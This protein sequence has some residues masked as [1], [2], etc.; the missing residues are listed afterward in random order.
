[1]VAEQKRQETQNVT[2]EPKKRCELCGEETDVIL[3]CSVCGRF[4]CP[5]CEAAR[6]EGE[7]DEP[8]CEE[9]F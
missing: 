1:M 8:V 6:D 7:P 5:G 3:G 4:I 9:C 2:E